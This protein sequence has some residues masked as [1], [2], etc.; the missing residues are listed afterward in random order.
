M[1]YGPGGGYGTLGAGYCPPTEAPH[2]PAGMD[3]H[4]PTAAGGAPG[5]VGPP[6]GLG[7]S[8]K[9]MFGGGYCPGGAGPGGGY[10]APG[11][12]EEPGGGK[13]TG[14]PGGREGYIPVGGGP[15][16]TLEV[17]ELGGKPDGAA[18]GALGALF[19]GLEVGQAC[20][21]WLGC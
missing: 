13:G 11:G 17:D 7:I 12:Q 15:K 2:P 4:A 3:P 9:G 5:S 20:G 21:G 19:Q 14:A 8:G 16:G 10:G 6:Y 18:G 1:E